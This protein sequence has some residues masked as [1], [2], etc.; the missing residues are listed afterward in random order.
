MPKALKKP[1]LISNKHKLKS[2]QEPNITKSN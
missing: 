2:K 1:R